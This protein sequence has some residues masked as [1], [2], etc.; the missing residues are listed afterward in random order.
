MADADTHKTEETSRQV[1]KPEDSKEKRLSPGVKYILLSTVFFALMNLGVKYLHNIPAYEIVFFRALVSLIVCYF[2]I[3]KAGL[4][5][6]GNNKTFLIARG[7]AG[8]IALMMYFYTLQKMPLASA[9]TIQYLSPIFTII[10]AGFMLKEQP[11]SGQWIFFLVSFAGVVM[12]KGFDP[13]VS[14]PELT[15]GITAACI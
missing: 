13:R 8:T 6:W 4:Y 2:M 12:I 14:V 10:I 11:R 1:I 5:L 9:V 3:R 15:I 7:V